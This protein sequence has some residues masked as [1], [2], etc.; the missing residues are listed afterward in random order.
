MHVKIFVN[1]INLFT[2]WA[3]YL[4]KFGDTLKPTFF[5]ITFTYLF[6]YIFILLKHQNDRLC[7]WL[8]NTRID[9]VANV[10]KPKRTTVLAKLAFFTQYYVN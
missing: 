2:S 6:S 5:S 4:K 1:R 8:N 7:L 9:F 3:F 10:S